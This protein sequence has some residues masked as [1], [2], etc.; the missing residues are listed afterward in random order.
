MTTTSTRRQTQTAT[1]TTCGTIAIKKTVTKKKA[2]KTTEK[3]PLVAIKGVDLK[4][5]EVKEIIKLLF[6][7][8]R[9]NAIE[10]LREYS[11]ITASKAI[12]LLT[13]FWNEDIS[14]ICK[15][16]QFIEEFMPEKCCSNCVGPCGKKKSIMQEGIFIPS[17]NAFRGYNCSL[18]MTEKTLLGRGDRIIILQKDSIFKSFEFVINEPFVNIKYSKN[19]TRRKS[20]DREIVR[21]LIVDKSKLFKSIMKLMIAG[22]IVK[23]DLKSTRNLRVFNK[24]PKKGEMY[25]QYMERAQADYRKERTE[26]RDKIKKMSKIDVTKLV[27]EIF[28]KNGLDEILSDSYGNNFDN[29]LH[30]FYPE[31]TIYEIAI[32]LIL[33]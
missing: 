18:F 10:Q 32:N 19:L 6:D 21:Y 24:E 2:P 22:W 30:D 26:A 5:D 23:T 7:R 15:N 14:K 3:A 20:K 12:E 11:K 33:K 8:K 28:A 31:K 4:Y 1:A 9:V 13:E 17:D 29:M 25:N 16:T 27:L